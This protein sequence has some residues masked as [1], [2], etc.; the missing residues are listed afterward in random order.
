MKKNKVSLVFM[1]WIAAYIERL[2]SLAR[3]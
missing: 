3:A 2:F 1:S